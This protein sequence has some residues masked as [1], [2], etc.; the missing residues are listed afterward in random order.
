MFKGLKRIVYQVASIDQARKWYSEILEMQPVFDTPFAVIFRVGDC[1]LSLVQVQ[2]AL[3][4]HTEG[5]ETYW[6]VEDIEAT[7]QRLIDYGAN[8]HTPIK[9]ALNTRLAK[10]IDPFGNIIG[11]TGAVLDAE[12]RSIENQPSE[13]AMT[14]AFC[15]ALAAKDERDA[16]KGPDYLAELFLTE[17]GRKPLNDRASRIWAIQNLVTAPLYGYFIAR[18]AF[19]DH[20]FKQSLAVDIPQIVFLGAGYD[21][22]VYR[23]RDSI[24]HTRIFELD[25]QSTQKR[26]QEILNNANIEIPREVTFVSINFKQDQ[27][28]DVLS[29]ASFDPTAKTLFIWEGVTYYLTEEAVTATL[30]F[31]KNN[32][33]SG[34][35]LCFDYLTEQLESVNT[36]EPFKFW[37]A[38]NNIDKFMDVHCFKIIEHL[39]APEM[40]KR[41]LSMNDGT[42]AEKVLTRFCFVEAIV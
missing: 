7:Y 15:R 2:S 13:T 32:S 9:T 35:I 29:D 34:S 27:L 5:V 19:I 24:Q 31:I 22:R 41:Y 26:K 39:D 28:K 4:D 21:T 8:P 30:R 17:E 40:E 6:E 10:V 12:K 38:Q 11:I 1:S 36:A 42:I 3:P 37:I 14:V 23:Y 33:P 18:T 20:I 16:I 25:I